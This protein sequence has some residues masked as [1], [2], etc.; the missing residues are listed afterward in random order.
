MLSF[1]PGWHYPSC[2]SDGQMKVPNIKTTVEQLPI[3]V[4]GVNSVLPNVA[5]G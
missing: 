5:V 3:T 2:R 1:D 4:F